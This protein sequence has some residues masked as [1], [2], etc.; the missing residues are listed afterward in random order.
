MGS[1]TKNVSVP[2]RKPS[3]SGKIHEWDLFISHASEDKQSI[4]EPLAKA[5][6]KFGLRVWYDKFTLKLGDSLSRSVSKG[7]A[8]S[9]Y[10]LVVLSP[11][12]F[13]KNWPAWELSGLTARE[14]AGGKVILPIWHRVS[15]SKV[16]AF[17]P[18]LADKKALV[19]R[20]KTAVE[21]AISVIEV[22][23]PEVFERIHR[24]L[25]SLNEKRR[26]AMMDPR[27]ITGGPVRHRD[28]PDELV[29]RIR[30]IR[31]ALLGVYPIR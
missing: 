5:L 27:D 4:V 12:F 25:A 19:S 2:K 23:N 26:T 14:L 29:G 15:R 31:A 1:K 28:L 11:A 16:L 21:L 13:K 20:G 24:R 9:K 10:G 6:A 7:I 22:T 8:R 17:S 18:P 3:V 30:L